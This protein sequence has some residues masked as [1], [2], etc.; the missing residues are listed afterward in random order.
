MSFVLACKLSER[1]AAIGSVAGAHLLPWE[2]CRPTRAV[3]T[4][5]FHGTADHV[6]PYQGGPSRSFEIPF[7]AIPEWVN[8][9]AQRNGCGNA[10]QE[11][12]PNG[13][14]SGIQ[15]TNCAFNADVIFYT[16]AGGGHSWPGGEPM[17]EFIVGYTT[18]D[19]EATKIMW[20]FFQQHPL[21]GE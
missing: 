3:P 16:V 19:I 13:E 5:V 1:I 8:A 7:P 11:I 20:D 2:E 21:T 18:R 10:P 15:F 6:V 17:P 9:L 12:P 14:V 4:I